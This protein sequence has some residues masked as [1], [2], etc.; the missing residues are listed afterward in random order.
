MH[1]DFNQRD[2]YGSEFDQNRD[3][4]KR[5]VKKETSNHWMR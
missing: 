3:E 5:A 2:E 1:T 4:E